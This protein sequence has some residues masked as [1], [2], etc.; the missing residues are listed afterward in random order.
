MQFRTLNDGDCQSERCIYDA[1][2]NATP[3]TSPMDESATS[4]YASDAIM[5]A[6]SFLCSPT[7]RCTIRRIV[8][9]AD[10]IIYLETSI[11]EPPN[12]SY[13]R[14]LESL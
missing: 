2:K 10:S 7:L 4:A 5:V 6:K 9:S 13:P 3:T 1:H 12:G 11:G 14:H 8:E